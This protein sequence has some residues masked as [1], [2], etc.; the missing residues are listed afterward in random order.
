MSG[1]RWMSSRVSAWKIMK[2][3]RKKKLK[4]CKGGKGRKW[5]MAQGK[6]IGFNTDLIHHHTHHVAS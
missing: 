5:G 4:K 1:G 3:T 6:G 2:I